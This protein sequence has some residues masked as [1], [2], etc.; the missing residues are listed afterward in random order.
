MMF[1]R[2]LSMGVAAIALLALS[3][4]GV[5]AASGPSDIGKALPLTIAPTQGTLAPGASAW[6]TFVVPQEY[7]VDQMKHDQH[8]GVNIAD[9][10][11]Y[12]QFSD[13]SNSD[14]AHN[15]GFRLYDP[16]HAGWVMNGVLPP[17]ARNAAGAVMHDSEGD[18][19]LEQAWW[20]IGSPEFDNTSLQARADDNKIDNFVNRPKAWDGVLHAAGTYYVQVY[21]ESDFPMSY[22]LSIAGPNLSLAAVS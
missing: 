15:T 5:S 11:I 17:E 1:R 20:A 3:V 7:S 9:Q 14:V 10:Q 12:L 8:E 6:F 16:Q 2:L 18:T 19:V 4:M 21:N 13:A 22:S